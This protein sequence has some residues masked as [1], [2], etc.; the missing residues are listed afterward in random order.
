MIVL[1]TI[2]TCIIFL[3]CILIIQHKKLNEQINNYKNQ[4]RIWQKSFNEQSLVDYLT[5]KKKMYQAYIII[6]LIYIILIC[7]TVFYIINFIE[8]ILIH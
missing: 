8:L 2:F 3:L 4:K 1:I 7:S 5:A 6:I